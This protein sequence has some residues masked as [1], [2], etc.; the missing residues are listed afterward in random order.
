M[1]AA[2]SPELVY[3]ISENGLTAVALLFPIGTRAQG[4]LT[5]PPPPVDSASFAAGLPLGGALGTIFVSG[6]TGKPGLVVAAS[7]SPLSFELAGVRVTVNGAPAPILAVAIPTAGSSAPGQINF[8]VPLERNTT[9]GETY[10]MSVSQTG[11][12]QVRVPGAVFDVSYLIGG[13]FADANQYVIAQHA[14]DYSTVTVQ[15]PAHA[16]ETIIA[17]ANNFFQ[18]WPP[19]PIGIPVPSQPL[20]QLNTGV[21]PGLNHLVLVGPMGLQMASRSP[22]LQ[23]LF[24]GLAPG[25][26]GVEQLNIVI[27]A[28][29]GPGDWALIFSNVPPV[30]SCNPL[31]DCKETDSRPVYLPVR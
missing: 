7:L 4:G 11:N 29:Q 6:L 19:P 8:Q 10:T 22:D 23:I 25:L 27:P 21:Y 26:V 5:N 13:F 12:G 15:N 14:S 3:I 9:A 16:G 1:L 18:V 24:A 20:F 31:K 30:G 17:Y 2:G 28:N